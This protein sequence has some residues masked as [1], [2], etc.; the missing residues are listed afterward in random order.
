ML[1][2]TYGPAH[3]MF[4]VILYG[5]LIIQIALLVY[6]LVKRRV[7]SRYSLGALL[8]MEAVTISSFIIGRMVNPNI[9]IMPL[10]YVL[11]GFS[12]ICINVE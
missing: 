4:Y 8:I 2:Q 3:K 6:S 7:V 12:Y 9:E 1:G 11:D 5:Y 10:V